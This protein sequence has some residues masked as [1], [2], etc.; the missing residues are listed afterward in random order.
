MIDTGTIINIDGE[1]N[2]IIAYRE[3]KNVYYV[4]TCREIVIKLTSLPPWGIGGIEYF[5]QVTQSMWR[6]TLGAIPSIILRW[7]AT[8][9]LLWN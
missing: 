9:L 8:K 7:I 6:E 5:D 4:W 1:D 3:D 2:H